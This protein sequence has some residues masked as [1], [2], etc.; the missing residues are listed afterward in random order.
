MAETRGAAVLEAR[1]RANPL[2]RW[3]GNRSLNTKI[4]S[5]ILLMAAVA[6][7]V[8]GFAI[9]RMASMNTTAQAIYDDGVVPLNRV[10]KVSAD[11]AATRLSVLGHAISTTDA[12]M[13][14][15][16]QKIREADQAFAADLD[17]YAERSA[18]PELVAQLRDT[19]ANYQE[20]RGNV[21]AASRR[22]DAVAVERLRDRDL[23]PV[24]AE[25]EQLVT[26][27]VERESAQAQ[28]QLQ[29]SMETYASGRALVITLLICGLLVALAFGLLVARMTVAAVRRVSG[30]VQAVAEGDL[31][32]SAGV[33]TTDELGTMAADLDR[34]TANLRATVERI[35]AS[36][37]QLADASQELSAVSDQI[38]DSAGQTSGRADSVSAAA[39]QV[40]RNIETVA[41]GSE[42]MTTSIREIANSATEAAKIAH[43]AVGVA[44]SANDT[45]A[46]LGQ[47][48]AEIGNVVSMI[49]SIAEQTN[50]L[51][52]NATIEAARAGELG[53]GFA[54][55]ASEVKDLAQATAKATEDV[56]ARVA[57]IQHESTEAVAAIRQISEVIEKINGYSATIASAVE[58]QTATSGEIG[59]NVT[60]A[61]AGSASIVHDITDVAGAAQATSVGVGESQRAARELAQ[62][63]TALQQLVAQFRV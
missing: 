50:L 24:A 42:E 54:V 18:A 16:E 44:A 33:T 52:L 53:K 29:R 38:G 9:A 2:G 17:L 23:T 45:I 55:V 57:D 4:T 49:T 36:G 43:Q 21:L 48:S 27:L 30:V 7:T 51:A 41:A 63:S 61:A 32:R 25:A 20:A 40:S 8:G 58:E 3:L 13:T 10:Q 5:G 19:W 11:M 31:T 39:E 26:Q 62:M 47:S 35:G 28:R 22:D 37:G 34:A 56:S 60:Q 14:R 1:V 6:V 59:R 15:Y 46:R 12:S